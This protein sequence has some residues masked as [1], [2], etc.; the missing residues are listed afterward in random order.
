MSRGKSKNG[1]IVSDC[2]FWLKQRNFEDCYKHIFSV[3]N[4]YSPAG[5]TTKLNGNFG[6]PT[7]KGVNLKPHTP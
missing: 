4:I 1:K 2:R 7:K 6:Y 5:F 3:Y